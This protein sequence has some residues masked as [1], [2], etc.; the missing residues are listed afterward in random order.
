MAITT[1]A[2]AALRDEEHF[3]LNSVRMNESN[4]D[5]AFYL[6]DLVDNYV[7][8]LDEPLEALPVLCAWL[9]NR[10]TER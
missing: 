1:A 2:T 4:A 5:V 6:A 10:I 9:V 7:A 3:P 8:I